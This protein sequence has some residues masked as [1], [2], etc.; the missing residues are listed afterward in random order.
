[1]LQT[2]IESIETGESKTREAAQGRYRE[3]LLSDGGDINA[4][5]MK[6]L[7]ATLGKTMGDLR[8]D[9]AVVVEWRQLRELGAQRE[10]LDERVA[11]AAKATHKSFEELQH[12]IAELRQNHH[13]V[14]VADSEM[15]RQRDRAAQAE[16]DAAAIEQR[17]SDL[18]GLPPQPVNHA[19]ESALAAMA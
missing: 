11:A 10:S 16:S 13:R 17:R 4:G 2:L 19:A 12:R 8:A 3:L 15:S 9:Y 6:K 1:M 7:L 14:V 5:E 18:F